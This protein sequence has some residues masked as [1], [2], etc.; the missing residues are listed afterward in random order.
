MVPAKGLELAVEEFFQ[1]FKTPWR[2]SESPHSFCGPGDVVLATDTLP[3][4]LPAGEVILLG[5]QVT[6]LDR[7]ASQ[8]SESLEG[9]RTICSEEGEFPVYTG[10]LAFPHAREPLAWDKETGFPVGY[11]HH[12]GAKRVLRLGYDLFREVS[13]LLCEGQPLSFARI[14]TLEIHIAFLRKLLLSAGRPVLEIPPRPFQ[15]D[16]IACLTHDVD[17]MGIRDH[18]FDGSVIGFVLRVLGL[19]DARDLEGRISL[20]LLIRNWKA[21]LSLPAVHLGLCEDFWLDLKRYGELER[22][23]PSTF[24]FVPFKGKPGGIW[25]GSS[26]SRKRGV[27]YDL[28]SYRECLADLLESGRE[29]ALHGIDAWADHDLA[30][31]ELERI[32]CHNNGKTTG[33]RMH[34]LF[35]DKRSPSLL[36]K[37]RFAYDS[38]RGYNEA[39]GFLSGTSQVY[40]LWGT[41]ALLE[42]P[43]HVM[44]TALFYKGRM[45]LRGPEAMKVTQEVLWAVRRYGGVFTVNWHTRSLGPERNWDKF[46]RALLASLESTGA[47]FLAARDV[48]EWFAARR[49]LS[50]K[51]QM[52]GESCLRVKLEGE[53]PSHLPPPRISLHLPLAEGL[54]AGRHGR[55]SEVLEARWP[56]EKE[57]QFNW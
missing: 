12:S 40:R 17:F 36:E 50:F 35:F 31:R 45:G 29:I 8:E 57:I 18:G 27:K 44:D 13:W 7:E 56:G 42:L 30:V 23:K 19:Q 24:F 32:R 9:I 2:Y 26:P 25:N 5:S 11:F 41:K 10:L 37:A 1:L 49:T 39:V 54:P 20:P 34:W 38:T 28:D 15:G 33:V 3:G 52:P 6:E 22:G 43:L 53:W 16:F 51:Q 14:P 55:Q 46:Y 48:V 4:N 21:L 47:V